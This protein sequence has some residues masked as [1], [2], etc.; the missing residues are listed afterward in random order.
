MAICVCLDGQPQAEGR[1]EGPQG[2]QHLP[3]GAGRRRGLPARY[4][5]FF[6]S[7]IQFDIKLTVFIF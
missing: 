5:V 4:E 2:A 6:F 1:A 7:L 3:P